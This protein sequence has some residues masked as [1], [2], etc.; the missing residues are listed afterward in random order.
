MKFTRIVTISGL[1]GLSLACGG[2]P[3]PVCGPLAQEGNPCVIERQCLIPGQYDDCGL[4]GYECDDGRW[5]G[6]YTYCNPPMPETTACEQV[7]LDA[8]C[9]SGD[10]CEVSAP[11]DCGIIG[12]D[13]V[14]GAWRPERMTCNPPP[15]G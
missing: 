8:A 1:G 5:R 12:Y 14:D 3:A 6:L 11:E 15:S 10:I 4:N 7:D 9:N 13:C 2:I